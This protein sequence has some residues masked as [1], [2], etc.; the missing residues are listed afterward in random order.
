MTNNKLKVIDFSSAIKAAP[1]NQNYEVIHKWM[2]R[3]RLRTGGFGLVEGF[4]MT[5]DGKF[6]I[7]LTEGIL[8]DQDG[9]EI[10]VPETLIACGEPPYESLKKEDAV[11]AANGSIELP[12]TPYSPGM[13]KLI[14]KDSSHVISVD[15]TELKVRSGDDRVPIVAVESNKVFVSDRFAGQTVTVDYDYCANRVDAILVDEHGKYT[16]EIGINAKSASIADYMQGTKFLIG[17][18]HWKVSEQGVSVEF[19]VD[20]R[21]YRKVYVDGLNRLYLNGKLYKE[22]KWIYFEEPKNPEEN[23]VWYDYQTNSLSVWSQRAG[24]YGWRVINDFTTVPVR[25]IKLWTE[26][27]CPVDLQTFTFRDDETDFRFIPGTNALEITIDQQTVMADQFEEVVMPNT[28]PYLAVGIGF[29]LKAPLDRP[30]VVQCTINHMVKNGPLKSV[31]QRAAIFTTENFYNYSSDNRKQVFETDLPYVIG[32]SQLEVFVDGKRLNTNEFAEMKDKS[33]V[34]SEKDHGDTSKFFNVL[35]PLR[36]GQNV[37][38]KISRYVWSYDQLNQM[39]EEIEHKAEVAS[40]TCEELKQRYEI[41]TKNF[42]DKLR[43]YEENVSE[44][45]DK[46]RAIEQGS[47][48]KGE[49]IGLSDLSDDVKHSLVKSLQRYEYNASI[50]GSV[51][52]DCKEDDFVEVCCQNRDGSFLLQ[53]G[54]QYTLKY[55]EG[56]AIVN[57]EPEWMGPDN[58][59]FVN[60]IRI[61]RS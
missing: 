23:D 16:R 24:I 7:H 38:Y 17:F 37:T 50:V 5:Y 41:M 18:A 31:F 15:E 42:E 6:G 32:A 28:K 54:K 44:L 35:T 36:D 20:E 40:Q 1:F 12:N 2:T 19:L 29:K 45:M 47:R 60:I 27:M 48:N 33:A 8:I 30:C 14:R 56:N 49:K 57:L 52:Y 21:T 22:A 55:Q 9:E 4:D 61:G 39:M 46:L 13:H 51:I 58:T 26:D 25:S 10:I 59:V 34:A 11:V 43:H 3:E 53:K